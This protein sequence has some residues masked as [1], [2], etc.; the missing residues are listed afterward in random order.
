MAAAGSQRLGR[1]EAGGALDD[2]GF[3][4]SEKTSVFLDRLGQAGRRPVRG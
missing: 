4:L 3:D 1:S 2:Q